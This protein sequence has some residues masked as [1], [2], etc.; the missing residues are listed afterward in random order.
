MGFNLSIVAT[1]LLS[2]TGQRQQFLHYRCPFEAHLFLGNFELCKSDQPILV[3]NPGI[4]FRNFGIVFFFVQRRV[5]LL[6]L[7]SFSCNT[8]SF[9]LNIDSF[10]YYA[11]A[12]LFNVGL[13][14][15]NTGAFLPN[16][17]SFSCNAGS[18]LPNVD[19]FSCNARSFRSAAEPFGRMSGFYHP[20]M[21]FSLELGVWV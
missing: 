1:D 15:C 13:F 4:R 11:G 7:D 10:S 5:F 9:L 12:F 2:P 17:D 21:I 6:S 16:V 14:S 20:P 3:Q 18:F 19:S 8:R